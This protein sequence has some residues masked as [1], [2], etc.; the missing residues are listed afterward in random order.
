MLTKQ[1]Q[2]KVYL[3]RRKATYYKPIASI[4]NND[5]PKAFLLRSGTRR[6]CPWLPLPFN[7]ILKVFLTRAIRQRK[8]K[9]IQTGKE[10][11]KL[12]LFADAVLYLEKP[13]NSTKKILGTTND[14]IKWPAT[15]LTHKNLLHVYIQI[16]E[17]TLRKQF[18]SHAY[19]KRIK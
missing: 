13:Q 6:G 15:K 4:F 5:K 3:N 19:Q 2:K 11:V 16:M 8:I 18:L 7:L 1:E 9:G 17:E 10:E 12:S 14:L